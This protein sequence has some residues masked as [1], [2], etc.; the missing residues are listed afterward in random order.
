[1]SEYQ[2]Y[3][4][5]AI[6]R[7]LTET[8]MQTLRR[9]STRA[10]ITP[11]SFV[12]EYHWGDFK[13]DADAWMKRYFDAFLYF[14]NWGTRILQLRLSARLLGP[15]IVRAYCDGNSTSVRQKGDQ[16]ILT[17]QS[18]FEGGDDSCDLAGGLLSSDASLARGAG[19]GRSARALPRLARVHA[20]RRSQRRRDRANRVTQ[21]IDCQCFIPKL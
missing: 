4:F 13:G 12:N 2:Y 6:D 16:L 8:E 17:F 20:P 10:Q 7:R 15:E 1:M 21:L 18:E 14:A 3:E 5:Q 11:T 19:V 9:Y